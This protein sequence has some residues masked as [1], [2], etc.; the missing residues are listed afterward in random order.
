MNKSV[1]LL[2]AC[3]LCASM[4]CLSKHSEMA[5]Q[6]RWCDASL[7]AFAIG[8]STQQPLEMQKRMTENKACQIKNRI[9]TEMN[10]PPFR[11][12]GFRRR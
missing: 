4:G 3:L 9:N 11:G 7:P 2:V 5:V 6:N 8:R 1:L 10:R 12:G